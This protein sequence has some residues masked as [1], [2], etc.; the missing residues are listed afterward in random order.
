MAVRRKTGPAPSTRD[1]DPWRRLLDGAP[2]AG[3]LVHPSDGAILAANRSLRRRCGKICRSVADWPL[4]AKDRSRL[5]KALAGGRRRRLALIG[6]AGPDRPS[7]LFLEPVRVGRR[8]AVLIWVQDGSADVLSISRT[9]LDHLPIGVAFL[10]DRRF[11][12]LN[13]AMA[14]MFGYDETKLIGKTTQCFYPD[15]ASYQALGREAYPL[16]EAGKVYVYERTMARKDGALLWCRITGRAI[17][18][19]DLAQGSIWII[20]DISERHA[21]LATLRD[22]R[23]QL[24]SMLDKAPVPFVIT[25]VATSAVRYG[26]PRAIAMYGGPFETIEGEPA[27]DHYVDPLDR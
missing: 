12:W 18:P 23:A 13:A 4:E 26:N 17:D 14:R 27:A 3:A 1:L 5:L 2:M 20:E 6:Q 11:F 24:E 9:I 19:Q 8:N 7:E 22:T 15:A 10:K 21:A 16:L 25:S